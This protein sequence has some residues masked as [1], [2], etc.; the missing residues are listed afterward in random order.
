M[1]NNS[2][3]YAIRAPVGT[4]LLAAFKSNFVADMSA[5]ANLVL[6]NGATFSTNLS[7][8]PATRSIS[9]KIVDASNSSLGLPGVLVPVSTQ[10]GLLGISFTD[11]NGHFTAE[12]GVSQCK[13]GNDSAPIAFLGYVGLQNKMT[14][15]TTAGNVSGVTIDLPKATALVYGTVKD[16]LGNPLPGVV[17]IYANDNNNGL[18]RSDG[19]TPEP[20]SRQAAWG[21]RDGRTTWW[22]GYWVNAKTDASS[23]SQP[24]FDANG[25]W[26]GDGRGFTAWRR[27]GSPRVPSKVEWLCS[28]SGRIPPN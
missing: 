7:L 11:S 8:I 14:V 2:G 27:G 5:A 1:A 24:T 28:V 23:S 13:I 6:G 16:S 12:A 17:A 15:D 18:Y 4:Y 25:H 20:K 9:G 22:V 3:I 26:V 19:Y 21:N 10:N